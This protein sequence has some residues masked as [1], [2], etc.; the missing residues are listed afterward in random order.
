MNLWGCC[1]AWQLRPNVHAPKMSCTIIWSEEP[2]ASTGDDSREIKAQCDLYSEMRWSH[3]VA[4]HFILHLTIIAGLVISVIRTF[5]CAFITRHKPD[6]RGHCISF[7]QLTT[8]CTVSACKQLQKWCTDQ[9][10]FDGKQLLR[11]CFVDSTRTYCFKG[12]F[13]SLFVFLP[14]AFAN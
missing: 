3:I 14:A 9:G 7:G 11:C 1:E 2:I 10:D 13:L 6:L 12:T 4:R 5:L 8:V